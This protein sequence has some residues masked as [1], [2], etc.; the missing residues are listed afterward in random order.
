MAEDKQVEEAV[1]A[2]IEAPS[3][4]KVET[5]AQKSP[6]SWGTGAVGLAVLLLG[7]PVFAIYRCFE[8]HIF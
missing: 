5:R 1:A 6:D 4:D 3:T 7:Q 2:P 8:H